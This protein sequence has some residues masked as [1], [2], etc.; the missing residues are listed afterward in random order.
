[1]MHVREIH[2]FAGGPTPPRPRKKFDIDN[3]T[4]I[5]TIYS[6]FSQLIRYL[7]AFGET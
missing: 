4:T 3:N 2:I 5:T 6:D 7:E 1:M